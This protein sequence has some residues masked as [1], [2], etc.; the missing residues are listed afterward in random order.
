MAKGR[1]PVTVASFIACVRASRVPTRSELLDAADALQ[2]WDPSATPIADAAAPV[3]T[4][5]AAAHHRIRELEYCG[6]D[7][8][9]AIAPGCMHHFAAEV[10]AA[11]ADAKR[12]ADR[13][14]VLEARI[15]AA[16]GALDAA[17]KPMREQFA[18]GSLPAPTGFVHKE[19]K[20]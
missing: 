1:P 5:L 8:V 14:R 6:Q 11:Q 18:P 4:E 13:V 10:A 7:G 19:G 12:W 2:A 3:L 20:R 15:A 17:D 16:R 9:C